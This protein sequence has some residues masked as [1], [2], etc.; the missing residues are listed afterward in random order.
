MKKQKLPEFLLIENE[1]I[2][3]KI[4]ILTMKKLLLNLCLCALFVSC[5]LLTPL[6]PTTYPPAGDRPTGGRMV[7]F[8]GNYTVQ[9]VECTGSRSNQQ[10]EIVLMITNKG[11]NSGFYIGGDV[12]GT[13][14]VDNYGNTLYPSGYGSHY[15]FPTG[16]PVKIVMRPMKLADPRT[17]MLS[18]L[19]IGIGDA[20]KIVE[21]RNIPITWF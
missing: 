13:M 10:I 17:S 9:I 8:Q 1:K 21:F 19:K 16:V 3:L 12:Y 11:V 18:Y 7:A 15:E 14:A 4:I 5:T 2:N 6:P 20:K